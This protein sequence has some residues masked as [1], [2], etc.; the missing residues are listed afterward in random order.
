MSI[1]NAEARQLAVMKEVL[2]D[3][4]QVMGEYKI[5]YKYCLS[6]LFDFKVL[7]AVPGTFT[8]QNIY[9]LH[10]LLQLHDVLSKSDRMMAVVK[11][12]FGDD[13]RVKINWSL[14]EYYFCRTSHTCILLYF[15]QVIVAGYILKI[16][17]ISMLHIILLLFAEIYRF[18]KCNI[19]S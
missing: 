15:N 19:C 12:L 16:F 17:A 14:I 11:D 8:F 3:Q 7:C 10:V 5:S 4:Q 9:S 6:S 13:P 18:S 1:S 2:Y